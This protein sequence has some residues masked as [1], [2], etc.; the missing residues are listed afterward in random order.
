MERDST[1]LSTPL[2]PPIPSETLYWIRGEDREEY[3]PVTLTDL[4]EWVAEDR[5]GNGCWVRKEVG[6]WAIWESYPELLELSSTEE[7]LQAT[8]ISRFLAFLIDYSL[9]LFVISFAMVYAW[10]DFDVFQKDV[11]SIEEMLKRLQSPFYAE[12]SLYMKLIMEGA[13]I[14]YFGWFLGRPFQTLGKKIMGIRVV[15]AEGRALNR[16]RGW[17]R[18]IASVISL[19]FFWAGYWIAIFNPGLRTLHDWLVQTRVVKGTPKVLP[20][21]EK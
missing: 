8:F 14:L 21:E 12:M 4:K 13:H 9:L 17:M 11:V 5:A 10:G 16:R 20:S 1:P 3:G 19:Q 7:F 15:D 2:P 6:D 18:G